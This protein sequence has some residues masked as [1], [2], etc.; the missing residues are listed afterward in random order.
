MGLASE[1]QNKTREFDEI[2]GI[3]DVHGH[4]DQNLYQ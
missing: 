1:T 2:E 3:T 4:F